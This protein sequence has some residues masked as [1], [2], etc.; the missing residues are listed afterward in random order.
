MPG[1]A[2][3]AQGPD[4]AAAAARTCIYGQG[5]DDRVKGDAG[6]DYA[7]G[8]PGIDWVEGDAGDDDLVGGSSTTR[9]AGS[10]DDDGRASPTAP[11]PSAAAPATTWRSAT[12]AQVLRPGHGPVR[13][14]RP[15]VGIGST[16]GTATTQRVVEPWDRT[17]AQLPDRAARDAASAATGSP[18]A[19]GVDV[20]SGQDGDD[21]ISGGGGDDYLE[22]NGGRRHDP[23]RPAPSARRRHGT[24]RRARGGVA[25][26]GQRR[27]RSSVGTGTPD[28]QD[29]LIG[30]SSTAGL[31]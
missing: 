1:P 15:P 16:A 25:G 10:G 13:R 17:A 23:R 18:V 20:L 21:T 4:L 2:P 7:E 22:G 11:T 8:G 31:P 9:R 28:G 29:D 26:S 3:A 6:D 5:G 27:R 12:T 19:H 24:T 30:G 14:R